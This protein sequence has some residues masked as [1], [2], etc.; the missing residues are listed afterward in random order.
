MRNEG[1]QVEREV[2]VGV[3]TRLAGEITVARA[4]SGTG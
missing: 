3:I 1:E 2:P 4:A